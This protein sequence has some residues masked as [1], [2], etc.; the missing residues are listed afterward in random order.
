[1]AKKRDASGLKK[2]SS[3]ATKSLVEWRIV[4]SRAMSARSPVFNCVRIV[5]SGKRFAKVFLVAL[6]TEIRNPANPMLDNPNAFDCILH[7]S[8]TKVMSARPD[9]HTT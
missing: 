4:P 6:G 3:V 2:G 7:H 8:V 9:D 5:S 1:M